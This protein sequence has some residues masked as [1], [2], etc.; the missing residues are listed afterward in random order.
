MVVEGFFTPDDQLPDC[1]DID[2]A[3]VLAVLA[4]VDAG[5]AERLRQLVEEVAR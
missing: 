1:F 3:H 2:A 4:I 5:G